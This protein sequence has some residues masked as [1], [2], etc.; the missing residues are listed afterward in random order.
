MGG[1]FC[2]FA[3]AFDYANHEVFLVQ[4]QCF[5]SQDV[6]KDWFRCTVRNRRQKIEVT[7][8]NSKNNFPFL[9][10]IETWI[11]PRI[12]SSVSV[13]HDIN[14]QLYPENKF[15]IRIRIICW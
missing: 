13:V 9:S 3:K 4:L 7:S 8:S 14:K 1:I 12:N 2:D 6:E 11:S 15:Y 10:Y 5:G